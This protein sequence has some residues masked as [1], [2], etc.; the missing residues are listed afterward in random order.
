MEQIRELEKVHVANTSLVSYYIADQSDLSHCN[1]L[2]TKELGT[3]SNIKSKTTRKEVQSGLR[4]IQ[5]YLR[6]LKKIPKNG[7]AIFAGKESFV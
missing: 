1:S 2:I 5:H 6:R 4:S 7:I 3:S